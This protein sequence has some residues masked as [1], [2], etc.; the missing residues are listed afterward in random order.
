MTT[1][2]ATNGKPAP[3]PA[4]SGL[5][6]IVAARTPLSE[7]DGLHGVLT[8][9]GYD[10]EQIA[11]KISLEEAAFLLWHG[12]LPTQQEL[13]DL[14]RRLVGYRRLPDEARMAVQAAAKR[15]LPMDALRFA[16]AALTADDPD[17]GNNA[18]EVNLTRAEMLVARVPI[19]VGMYQRL[20]SG[21]QVVEPRADLGITANLLFQMTGEEPDPAKVRGLETYFVTVTDHGMNASTFT[22]RVIASTASDMVSAVVGG[23]GALKGPLHGGAPGPALD[24]IE[25]IGT[26]DRAESWMKNAVAHGQRLMGFGHRVYK[27]R[28]PRAEVLYRA[29]WLLAEQTGEQTSLELAREVERVAINVLEEAKP[30]RNLNTNVEFYTALLLRDVGL[31]PDLF[32]CAFGIGRTVGWTAHVIEQHDSGRLIRPQSEYNGPRGLEFVPIE[33]R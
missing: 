1:G 27:V 21:G 30:G 24:M 7:V 18:H 23:V 31:T 6:G 8:I 32:S 11:S 22:T 5:E 4:T 33:K 12:K 25:S 14:H 17:P 28:D 3:D 9:R 29:A 15:M 20:R 13:D 26:P 10:I 2:S 16:V 19:I